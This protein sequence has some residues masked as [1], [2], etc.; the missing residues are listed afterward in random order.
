MKIANFNFKNL[1]NRLF[2]QLKTFYFIRFRKCINTSEFVVYLEVGTS[3]YGSNTDSWP[4]AAKRL[5]EYLLRKSDK[6]CFGKNMA[7]VLNRSQSEGHWYQASQRLSW[8][9]G[10][11]QRCQSYTIHKMQYV[12]GMICKMSSLD[13]FVLPFLFSR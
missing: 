8:G 1:F 4:F 5:T 6:N 7:A 2:F 13:T 11:R 10:D 12:I 9:F 3:L